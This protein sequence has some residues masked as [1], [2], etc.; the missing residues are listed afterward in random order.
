MLFFS[1]LEASNSGQVWK[2]LAI[3]RKEIVS[4]NTLLNNKVPVH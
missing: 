1:F 3:E 2:Y 4:S